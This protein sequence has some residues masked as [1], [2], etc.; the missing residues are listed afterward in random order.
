MQYT[1]VIVLTGTLLMAGHFVEVMVWAVTYALAGVAPA[2]IDLLYL[3]FGNYT[4]LGYADLVAPEQWR[5]APADDGAERHHADRLV[6]GA[7]NSSSIKNS[8]DLGPHRGLFHV[9]SCCRSFP[10]VFSRSP[11]FTATP[12]DMDTTWSG[13]CW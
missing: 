10:L 6:D 3:A 11:T 1:I 13:S 5:L 9:A 7:G 12:C 4:T 2:G 8:K